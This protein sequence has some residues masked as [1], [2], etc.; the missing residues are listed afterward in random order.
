MNL[1]PDTASDYWEEE[2]D[3][4]EVESFLD[5]LGNSGETPEPTTRPSEPRITFP[6]I[7]L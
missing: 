5:S 3:A 1:V 2:V 7:D 4:L 6:A